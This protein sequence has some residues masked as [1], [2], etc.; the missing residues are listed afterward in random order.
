MIFSRAWFALMRRNLVYRRRNWLGT[1]RCFVGRLIGQKIP[2]VSLN[3]L[4][5]LSSS[6]LTLLLLLP[7][8]TPLPVPRDRLTRRVCRHF[9]GHQESSGRHERVRTDHC[10]PQ[11]SYRRRRLYAPHFYRL[12]HGLASGTHVY[13]TS[14]GESRL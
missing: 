6:P 13:S 2:S 5:Y 1:V 9:A 3:A 4:T 12:C 10:R 11:L 14:R 8:R 7:L